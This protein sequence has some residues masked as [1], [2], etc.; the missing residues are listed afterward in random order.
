MNKS[1]FLAYE[2]GMEN[3]ITV[4]RLFDIKRNML[5]PISTHISDRPEITNVS[6]PMTIYSKL[7]DNDLLTIEWEAT[8][9][10]ENG[11]PKTEVVSSS[12]EEKVFEILDLDLASKD[13]VYVLKN[14]FEV[15]YDLTEKFFY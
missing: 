4:R 2:V 1:V 5:C 10:S 6:L 9:E 11:F 3:K 13:V 14:G 7:N 15:P 8:Y 12:L